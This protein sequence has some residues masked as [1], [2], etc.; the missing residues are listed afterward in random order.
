MSWV[1]VCAEGELLPGECTVAFAGDTAIVVCNVEG[2]YYALEDRC[3]H[4]DYELSAG[5]V[6]GFTI[7]CAL[8]GARFDLRDGRA[9]SPPAY[10]PVRPFPVK[11][12]DGAVWVR[13]DRD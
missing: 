8:H 6:E 11:C 13:D 5:H 10:L 7:E 2:A 3:S 1:R 4:E 9:L 12:E